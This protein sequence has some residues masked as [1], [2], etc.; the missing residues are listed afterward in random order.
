MS[1]ERES[2]G[3]EGREVAGWWFSC[4][5]LHCLAKRCNRVRLRCGRGDPA[6]HAKQRGEGRGSSQNLGYFPKPVAAAA[7]PG[8][9]ARGLT[10]VVSALGPAL[11]ATGPPPAGISRGGSPLPGEVAHGSSQ[12]TIWKITPFSYSLGA[13]GGQGAPC[14]IGGLAEWPVKSLADTDLDVRHGRVPV[15][16]LADSPQPAS[17]LRARCVRAALDAPYAPRQ[18][19]KSP[20]GH[21][22]RHDGMCDCAAREC[23]PSSRASLARIPGR[24]RSVASTRQPAYREQ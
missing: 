23:L 16:G 4:I 2:R 5:A 9:A 15:G 17:H 11:Q 21:G 10:R 20:F 14:P 18:P 24:P 19:G 8:P 1:R 13:W 12:V 3:H 22:A 6:M 7:N